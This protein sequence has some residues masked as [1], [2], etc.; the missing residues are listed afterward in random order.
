M[1]RAR[2]VRFGVAGSESTTATSS[3]G[4]GRILDEGAVN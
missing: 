2:A 4:D 3:Y 1:G